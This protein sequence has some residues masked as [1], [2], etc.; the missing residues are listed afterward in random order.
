[1]SKEQR[2]SAT[3]K[4]RTTLFSQTLLRLKRK[5]QIVVNGDFALRVAKISGEKTA[6]ILVCAN[7]TPV[8]LSSFPDHTFTPCT[9]NGDYVF[10]PL[11]LTK[12]E[13][14]TVG[15]YELRAFSFEDGVNVTIE[16]DR[17][18]KT[19]RVPRREDLRKVLA[20]VSLRDNLLPQ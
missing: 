13:F 11:S 3:N 5:N 17:A 8:N 6:L 9:K 2:K 4:E 20:N 15:D 1:M 18:I 19:G 12:G 16:A 7:K 10:F 14:A